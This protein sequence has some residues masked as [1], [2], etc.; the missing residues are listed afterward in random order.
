M[1]IP[2]IVKGCYRPYIRREIEMIQLRDELGMSLRPSQMY[3]MGTCGANAT[4]YRGSIDLQKL[5]RDLSER[6]VTWLEYVR[7]DFPELVVEFDPV[8]KKAEKVWRDCIAA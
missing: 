1:D 8:L 2:E 3:P 6:C 7:K 5:N 4:V